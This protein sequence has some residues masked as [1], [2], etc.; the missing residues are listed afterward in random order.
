VDAATEDPAG[1]LRLV[2]D[3]VNTRDFDE[4]TDGLATPRDLADWLVANGLATPD[5]TVAAADLRR[6]VELRESL[7]AALLANNE[8][9]P[10]SPAV[11]EVL[12]RIGQRATLV[13]RFDAAG[14]A[15]LEPA[16]GGV[17]GALGRLLAIVHDAT[18]TGEWGRLKAC[19]NDTCLWAFFDHSKNHSRHWCSME[20]CGSQVKARSYRRR[21]RAAGPSAGPSAGP[22]A[23]A[24]AGPSAGVHPID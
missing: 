15:A 19:R 20:S 22:I 17:D 4:D 7:R 5:T 8:G 14:G 6:A 9:A 16:S 10:P 18:A 23:D 12:N 24:S 2:R 21:R 1:P 11:L 3:F 13:T